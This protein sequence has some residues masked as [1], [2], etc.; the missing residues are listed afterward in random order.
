MAAAHSLAEYERKRDFT[1]TPEPRHAKPQ[2]AVA[3]GF[4]V[5][6]HAARHLHYDFR[7][8]LDGTLKS[9]AVPKG[10]CLDPSVKRMAVEV[11]DHPLSYANFEG[12]IPPKQYGAGTVIVWDRGTWR[13]VGNAQAGLKAGHL[14]FSLQGSK[15]AG[16]WALVR[17]KADAS[18]RNKPPAWLLIKE[19]DEAARPLAKFDVIK[20]RPGSALKAAP[21]S[22]KRSAAAKPV[23][24]VA[25]PARLEP[26]L[27][28]LVD[29]P[30]PGD[31]WHYEIKYDGYR[32]MTRIDAKG[33]RC[34]TRNGHDWSAKLPALVKALAALKLAPCWLDGEIV[35]QR[36][37]GLPDFQA[38]QN[39]FDRATTE[40]IRYFVFDLPFADGQDLRH[41]PLL[42]RRARLQSMLVSNPD[43][44]IQFSDTLDQDP[45][46][47]LQSAT[48]FGIEGLIGKRGSSVY[49]SGR[50]T[51]WIKLKSRQRQEF[52]VGGFTDL[53]GSAR[54]IGALVLGV[55]DEQGQLR[56]AGSVGTGFDEATRAAL[57]QR[58]SRQARPSSPFVDAPKKVGARGDQTPHWVEPKLVAEVSFAQWTSGHRI[59]HAVF[60]GLRQDKPVQQVA[61]ERPRKASSINASRSAARL[62]HADRV[63]DP[64]SGITKGE[65]ADFYE[66]VGG[67]LLPHLKQRPMAMLRA[68]E[69]IAA[70]ELFFQK[71]AKPTVA[72]KGVKALDPS[73]DPGHEPL[74]A[75]ASQEGIA[76]AVQMNAIEFHT[77]NMTTR[78]MP[79][80]D[81]MVFDLDPGEGVA[82][83]AVRES[84]QLIKAF[85]DE[86]GLKT[87]GLKT[88]G[89]KGLHVVV[90]L[91]ARH[92]WQL[93]RQASQAVVD[94]MAQVLPQRFAAKSGPRNRVGKVFIDYLRNGWGATTAAA[95]SARARPGLGVSVPIE[96]SELPEI[97]SGA[98]WHIRN[99][100]DRLAVGNQ[101]WSR[102]GASRQSLTRLMKALKIKPLKTQGDT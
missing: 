10:P 3:L 22:A 102:L 11:E 54:G 17:M 45:Q 40:S 56:F 50:S 42:Q 51:D 63:I 93:V 39:A 49:Q 31:D 80:A 92:E 9:W 71:H 2:P 89:G 43:A 72:L 57:K 18:G 62:T 28:T 61:H 90:P 101:P 59:R 84:A 30:P 6:E 7:L 94:H 13:P 100:A 85:L 33:V 77:W 78:S 26:Q 36:E 91:A 35:V 88:S 37:D 24:R 14:K 97:E 74:L 53:A 34:F 15:L 98:H 81:R 66:R 73:L 48:S 1:R 41:E 99:L 46:A 76:S 69:G 96:W 12:T 70:G 5:Q 29:A 65:L 19:K 95:W 58:L 68:P 20:A 64:Q 87:C 16:H 21:P 4:V 27:A 23:A 52:V 55:H 83:S 60:H 25:L 75:I 67:L 47:L 32:L 44:L 82:W 79:K 8:E 86:L 38:L